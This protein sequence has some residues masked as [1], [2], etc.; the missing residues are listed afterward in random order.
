[1]HHNPGKS[2]L[3]HCRYSSRELSSIIL[4]HIN[5]Q[6]ILFR[7]VKSESLK[8]SQYWNIPQ[9]PKGVYYIDRIR[10]QFYKAT[11]KPCK[12]ISRSH[13]LCVNQAM[14]TVVREGVSTLILVLRKARAFQI[15]QLHVS[16]GQNEAIH[17]RMR[18]LFKVPQLIETSHMPL[19]FSSWTQD[20]FTYFYGWVK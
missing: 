20:N 5:K 14:V 7:P 4:Q 11:W 12:D 16:C 10:H 18:D 17:Q 15:I 3:D 1:M 13:I 2:F 9:F 6:H 8:F 19:E